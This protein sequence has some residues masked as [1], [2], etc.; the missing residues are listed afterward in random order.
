[1]LLS[2]ATGHLKAATKASC[3]AGE[4]HD[5]RASYAEPRE[6]TLAQA[7]LNKVHSGPNGSITIHGSNRQ[8]VL[9]QACVRASAPTEAEAKSLASSIRVTQGAGNIE[10]DGP[11]QEHGRH[12]SVSYEVWLP[13]ASNLEVA[14]VNGGVRIEDVRGNIVANNVNGGMHLSR[15]GGDVKTTTV[16]GGVTIELNGTSWQGQ[17]LHVSTTNGGVMVKIPESYS[18]N[19]ETSTV[20][21]GINCDFPISI[22]GK[23]NKH[24]SF[25]LGGGGA[26]IQTSTV[27]GGIHLA[28]GV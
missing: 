8:D 26:P 27:N 1:M 13:A 14:T 10:A 6:E 20:N 28:R 5:G 4:W 16:N 12:W 23:I 19:F 2:F 17:G 9:V 7:P 22:Q 3:E 11:R 25:Q 21:G 15:L 24:F 18:A